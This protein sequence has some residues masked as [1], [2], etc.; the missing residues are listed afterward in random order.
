MKIQRRKVEADFIRA[1]IIPPP[2]P[3][4]G[5]QCTAFD[6]HVFGIALILQPLAVLPCIPSRE[7][8]DCS[9]IDIDP[10]GTVVITVVIVQNNLG[11][12]FEFVSVM[13]SPA[14]EVIERPLVI[15]LT[16]Y[17]LIE[18]TQTFQ[19]AARR[20]PSCLEQTEFHEYGSGLLMPGHSSS[21][22]GRVFC[23]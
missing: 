9:V 10:D 1:A 15:D 3:A 13:R 21:T 22:V 14:R 6:D 8:S 20:M 7:M 18:F 19:P 2:I 17:R 12:L 11:H 5:Y 23:R 16:G 4:S